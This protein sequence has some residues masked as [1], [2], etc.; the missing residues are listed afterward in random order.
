MKQVLSIALMYAF[1][2]GAVLVGIER[3]VDRREAVHVENCKSYGYGMNQWARSE[4]LPAIC[5]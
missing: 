4:G 1:L 5:P 2:I 3:E